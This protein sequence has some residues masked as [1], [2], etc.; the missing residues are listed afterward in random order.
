MFLANFCPNEE[1]ERFYLLFHAF[2]KTSNERNTFNDIGY[3]IYVIGIALA[4][5]HYY[6]QL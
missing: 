6:D 4:L 5:G 3:E 1:I 2:S